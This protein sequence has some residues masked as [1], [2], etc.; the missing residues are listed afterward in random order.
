MTFEKF[1]FSERQVK[2]Y[3]ANAKKDFATATQ[4]QKNSEICFRFGYDALIK[5][6]VS[7]CAQESLRVL[8]R[9]GHHVELIERM[10]AILGEDDISKYGN[11]MRKKRNMDIYGGGILLTANEAKIYFDFVKRVFVSANNYFNKKIGKTSLFDQ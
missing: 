11:K 2:I 8:S 3:Y 9:A 10:S 6:A 7:V 1:L 4:Y 5:L